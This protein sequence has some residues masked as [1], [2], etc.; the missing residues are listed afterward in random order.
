MAD[1]A[2]GAARDLPLNQTASWDGGEATKAIFAW[3]GGD[4]F[5]PARARKAF[6]VHDRD[7]DD[8]RGAYK[9]PF[10][11]PIDGTLTAV[12]AGIANAA[13]RLP[14]T[15][16]P[17]EVRNRARS[18][19]DGYEAKWQEKAAVPAWFTRRPDDGALEFRQAQTEPTEDGFSGYAATFM[20]ADSY[21]TCF[22]KG[23]FQKSLRNRR[24]RLPVL[25][26][27]NPHAPIGRHVTI[28]EDATGLAVDVHLIDDGAEGSTALKRLRGGIPL[29]LSF[30]F[31]TEKFRSPDDEDE[32]DLGQ[33]PGAKKNEIRVIT[34]VKLWES[35]V[36]T[37]AANEKAAIAAVR[38]DEARLLSLL[39]AITAG[40]LDEASAA[41]V[42]Q[43]VA[44]ATAR[45][46]APPV[47]L[48]ESEVPAALTDAAR[49]VH[50]ID[51]EL[52]LSKYRGVL[53]GVMP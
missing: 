38:S 48:P 10:A 34:E 27:H 41:Q 45:A 37:F 7:I 22:A 15:D 29:G 19:I 52:A 18:V 47:D 13:S 16:I 14:Q 36:V 30:G 43:I 11:R 5:N 53:R 20:T 33:V 21:G 39:D 12:R 9:L 25:W 23:C 31:Q 44:A 46:V 8:Q 50:R 42:Q 49:H 40:T 24:E 51:L 2:V 17:E 32:I 4:E 26:Q 28:K 3:A 6:L 35:S 1:W